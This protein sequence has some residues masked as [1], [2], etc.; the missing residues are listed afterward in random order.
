MSDLLKWKLQ[1]FVSTSPELGAISPAT[2]NIY[3]YILDFGIMKIDKEL[4]KKLKKKE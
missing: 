3:F 4:L 2:L 1:T